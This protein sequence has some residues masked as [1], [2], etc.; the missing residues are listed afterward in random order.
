VIS[1]LNKNDNFTSE[2]TIFIWGVVKSFTVGKILSAETT[3]LE[4]NSAMKSIKTVHVHN[5]NK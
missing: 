2:I 4:H 5:E 3:V 1:E